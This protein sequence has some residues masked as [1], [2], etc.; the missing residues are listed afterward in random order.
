MLDF[1]FRRFQTAISIKRDKPPTHVVLVELH[2]GITPRLLSHREPLRRLSSSTLPGREDEDG[3]ILVVK[4]IVFSRHCNAVEPA[5][6][7]AVRR[8]DIGDILIALDL[9]EQTLV[10]EG[11]DSVIV[12]NIRRRFSRPLLQRARVP[13]D[14]RSK[15]RQS[16]SNFLFFV[17]IL[18]Q[19]LQTPF[20]FFSLPFDLLGLR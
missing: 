16:S 20:L 19:R 12:D 2:I 3:Y 15:L 9:L 10:S 11:V 8:R 7:V 6:H 13:A 1:S 4:E 17:L 14:L 18:A 5:K